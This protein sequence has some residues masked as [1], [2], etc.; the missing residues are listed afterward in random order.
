MRKRL[1]EQ[2]ARILRDAEEKRKIEANVDYISVYFP[3]E[4]E[5]MK[6][7]DVPNYKLSKFVRL[8]DSNMDENFGER[9]INFWKSKI[10]ILRTGFI[11][12]YYILKPHAP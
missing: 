1:E 7:K 12:N 2:R 10:E 3:F 6:Y 11:F 5:E 9:V 4:P 8:V